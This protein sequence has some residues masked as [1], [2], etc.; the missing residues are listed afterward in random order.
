MVHLTLPEYVDSPML[1]PAVAER[2]EIDE[3]TSTR[4]ATPALMALRPTSMPRKMFIV[5]RQNTAAYRQLLLT[6]GREPGVEIIYDR[7]PAPPAK[8]GRMQR[9]IARVKRVIGRRGARAADAPG[10]R[11]RPHVD[12]ELRAKGWAVV[13]VDEDPRQ[14][15]R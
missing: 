1:D 15:P 11:Q 5:A 3:A 2:L 13:R 6:V 8:P 14:P 12:Q 9:L 7:R 4:F 10:R